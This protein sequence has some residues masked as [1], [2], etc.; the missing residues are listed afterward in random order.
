M[1]YIG[2]WFIKEM[3]MWDS[4]YVNMEVD[5]YIDIWD[6]CSGDFQ[7]GLMKG[8]L[9]YKVRKNNNEEIL[10]FRFNA[11]DECDPLIGDGWMKLI[12]NER[13]EGQFSFDNG[14]TSGFIAEY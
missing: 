4:D 5:G 3:D 2:K 12:E 14:D 13:V 10:E 9:R 7:F 1:D 6:E 11:V 8:E